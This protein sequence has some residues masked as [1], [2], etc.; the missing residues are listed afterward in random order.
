MN[1][2]Y[3][4]L[5]RWTCPPS[6][7]GTCS[8]IFHMHCIIRWIEKMNQEALCPLCK[9]PW[10]EWVG[11]GGHLQVRVPCSLAPACPHR[12]GDGRGE[13]GSQRVAPV[14]EEHPPGEE[15][16]RELLGRLAGEMP[17]TLSRSCTIAI[18]NCEP[19]YTRSISPSKDHAG[20]VHVTFRR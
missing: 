12:G 20:S 3:P 14:T 19:L 4:R 2:Y 8:H 10:R 5:T 13:S 7:F 1:E 17:A 6:V 18:C 9:R 16:R 11:R 15:P